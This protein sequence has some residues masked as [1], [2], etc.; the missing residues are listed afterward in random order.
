PA[1]LP[2]YPT[3]PA[4]G[5]FPHPPVPHSEEMQGIVDSLRRQ[6]LHP[7]PL[8]LGLI[9]PGGLKGCRLCDTCNS[10]PCR[11]GAK[12]DAEGSCVL[13]ALEHDNVTLWDRSLALRLTPKPSG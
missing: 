10:F 1:P 4:R 8:P 7:S 5:P 6:G 11:I 12:S 13:P 3:E 9:D 2:I